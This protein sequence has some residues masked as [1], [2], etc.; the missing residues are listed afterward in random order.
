MKNT[1]TLEERR[2]TCGCGH[3]E[4]RDRKAGVYD[5]KK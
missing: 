4:D 3:F 2:Y 5:R 1:L